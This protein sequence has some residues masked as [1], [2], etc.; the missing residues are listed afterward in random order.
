MGV[1]DLCP[2]CNARMLPPRWP[3]DDSLYCIVCGSQGAMSYCTNNIHGSEANKDRGSTTTHTARYKAAPH[4]EDKAGR[5]NI[6]EL[7]QLVVRYKLTYADKPTSTLPALLT[8]C[9]WC[10]GASRTQTWRAS[11]NKGYVMHVECPDGHYYQMVC[12]ADGDYYWR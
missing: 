1:N 4:Q 6:K 12:S 3:N 8:K 2:R 10:E 9:P 11:N 7:K 5:R